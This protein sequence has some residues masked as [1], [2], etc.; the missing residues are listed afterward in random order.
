MFVFARST[1]PGLVE[2]EGLF[3]THNA[4]GAPLQIKA[5]VHVAFTTADNIEGT[6]HTSFQWCRSSLSEVLNQGE[7]ERF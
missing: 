6:P 3:L 1:G 2:D 4:P 5:I 7:G